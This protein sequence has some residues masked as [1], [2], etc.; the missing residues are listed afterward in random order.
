VPERH[1]PKPTRTLVVLHPAAR[2]PRQHGVGLP[3]YEA[4]VDEH[5]DEEVHHPGLAGH[6]VGE[7]GLDEER[8]QQRDDRPEGLHR[9][10]SV[11][12]GGAGSAVATMTSSIFSKFAEGCTAT[13]LKRP[14]PFP[15]ERT[16]PTTSPLG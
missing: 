16:R 12:W 11:S 6:H 1:T 3:A 8:H 5:E 2:G 9:T 10:D 14:E 15:T 7:G 4:A 13:S